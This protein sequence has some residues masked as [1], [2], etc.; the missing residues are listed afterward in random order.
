MGLWLGCYT[1][2]A[3][4]ALAFIDRCST[5]S[6]GSSSSLMPLI[7]M[8]YGA[9]RERVAEPLSACDVGMPHPAIEVD[10]FPCLEHQ[11][12]I[13]VR[14][15]L[16]LSV[17]HVHELF[18]LMAHEFAE[19]LKRPSPILAE[20]RRE[21]L[22]EQIGAEVAELIAGFLNRPTIALAIYAAPPG[23]FGRSEEHTSEL[24][25]LTNLVC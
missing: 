21:L 8:G 3:N 11:R 19:L 12:R 18:T 13:T 9:Y 6:S 2:A 23:L 5:G 25:S 14:V 16:Q 7:C 22:V 17:Y 24:Q 10:G 20:N 1:P 15:Q 4:G